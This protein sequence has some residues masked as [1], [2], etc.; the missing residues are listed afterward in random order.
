MPLA[1]QGGGVL[2]RLAG[3]LTL[4]VFGL[5][6]TVLWLWV[7]GSLSGWRRLAG[8]YGTA[9]A[10]PPNATLAW[11][12]YVGGVSFSNVLWIGGSERGLHL[13][14]LFPFSLVLSPGLLIPWD[15]V[16]SRARTRSM[17]G[18]ARDV[19]QVDGVR[20]TLPVEVTRGLE[21]FLPP[22]AAA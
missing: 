16:S 8:V 2:L 11:G 19:V 12:V 13:R 5:A 21:R 20:I 3:P 15:A 17:F 1:A 9:E 7:A 22:L 14:C 4:L 6:S 18:S 10:R